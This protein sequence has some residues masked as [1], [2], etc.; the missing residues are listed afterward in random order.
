M[1][2]QM[3]AAAMI[4]MWSVLVM[5]SAFSFGYARSVALDFKK[6]LEPV[7]H[8]IKDADGL[9]AVEMP[10]GKWKVAP[11]RERGTFQFAPTD[12]GG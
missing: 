2:K 10:D 7:V 4:L 8:V 5:V 3:K 11:G 6:P 12:E 1:D 9:K